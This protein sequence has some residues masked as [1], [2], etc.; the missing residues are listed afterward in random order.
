MQLIDGRRHAAARR[1]VGASSVACLR[2]ASRATASVA[3]LVLMLVAAPSALGAP[4]HVFGATFGAPGSDPGQFSTPTGVVVSQ[5]SH[6][7][8]VADQSNARVQR[9]DADGTF[10]SSFDGSA[11]PSSFMSPAGIA[12]DEDTGDIYVADAANPVVNKFSS[13]GMYLSQLPVGGAGPNGIAVDPA[14]GDVYV[15]VND[16]P[17]RVSVFDSAGNPKPDI[18]GAGSAGELV[19][20]G[21]VAVDGTGAVYV[22][23]GSFPGTGVVKRFTTAGAYVS[24]VYA[25]GLA[26]SMGV[27]PVSGDLFVYEVPV[28]GQEPRIL[29]YDSSGA[30]LF[31]FGAGRIDVPGGF[32]WN[33]APGLAVDQGTGRV[34]VVNQSSGTVAYFNLVTLPD[35]VTG[36]ASGETATGATISGTV[37]P[38][39]IA[40]THHFV[41]GLTSAY[42]SSTP[43]ASTGDGTG[44]VPVDAQ[45][46]DLQPNQTYHYRLV[47]ANVS[48]ENRGEDQTLTTEAAPPSVDAQAPSASNVRAVNARLNGSVNPNNLPTAYHFEYG[49][50]D[51]VFDSSTPTQNLASSFGNVDVTQLVTGLAPDT[52]YYFRVVADNGTGGPV[53]GASGSF[54][55]TGALPS[56]TIQPA[57]GVTTSSATLHA[58]VDLQ[59]LAGTYRFSVQ[60]LDTAYSSVT[61]EAALGAGAGPQPIAATVTDLPAGQR[62]HVRAIATT[63]AGAAQSGPSEFQSL[64]L[65]FVP[66]PR[67]GDDANPYGCATP[68][69]TGYRGKAT[70]GKSITVLG[71]DLGLSGVLTFGSRAADTSSWNSTAVRF[72]VPGN[73]KGRVQVRARCGNVSNSIVVRVGCKPGH[74]RKT[75]KQGKKRVS[76]CVK[77]TTRK[78][79]AS[80]KRKAAKR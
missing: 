44:P 54:T 52:T 47:A 24:T 8:L 5:S 25:D 2:A 17:G 41:Y 35:V 33:A 61:P 10:I 34:Y 63:D 68:R 71:S 23:D 78:K 72:Q 16:F 11:T 14:N 69:L 32:F 37:D 49:T 75:V 60:G 20:A 67:P 46:A 53:E 48:G 40:T 73:A 21:G 27:D 55:T 22:M 39:G 26:T 38:L 70:P 1:I 19:T 4:G 57:T 59:G 13:D 79:G 29:H 36:S 77:K 9:F 3:V 51:G 50:T 64:P 45:L 15:A 66:A 43:D 12:V 42:G 62:F 58:T 31:T 76:R 74:V 30:L 56:V 80:N 6:E 7:V 28:D 65:V 18:T